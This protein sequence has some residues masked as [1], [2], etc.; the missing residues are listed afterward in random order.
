MKLKTIIGLFLLMLTPIPLK[1]VAQPSYKDYIKEKTNKKI[2]QMTVW[3][4][5]LKEDTISNKN[6][7]TDYF[8]YPDS[9]IDSKEIY[10]KKGLLLYH[11]GY[12]PRSFIPYYSYNHY[13]YDNKNRVIE[14]VD[15]NYDSSRAIRCKTF[16]DDNN[17]S[18]G[19]NEFFNETLSHFFINSYNKKGNLLVQ[20]GYQ[21]DSTIWYNNTYEYLSAKEVKVCFFDG[22]Y[23]FFTGF[24]YSSFDKKGN[25]T[26]FSSYNPD[27]TLDK[28]YQYTYNKKGQLIQ[29]KWLLGETEYVT[30]DTEYELDHKGNTIA[31]KDLITNII[32]KRL[33]YNKKGLL[34][35][36]ILYNTEGEPQSELRYEYIMRK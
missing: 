32:L 35:H 3:R 9:Y 28:G 25:R 26:E 6:N 2:A 19:R 30:K 27:S 14:E 33:Y 36:E 21:D 16:F 29:E 4:Y 7:T 13:K 12:D 1:I 23:S 5:Q 18:V 34:D 8:I 22:E 11:E 10:S 15:F 17:M 31:V 24:S 20:N